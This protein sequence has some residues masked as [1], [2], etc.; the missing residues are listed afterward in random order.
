MIFL[1]LPRSINEATI[2]QL[3]TIKYIDYEIAHQI[4]EQRTL[5]E[6][7]KSFD[8]LLKVKDFPVKKSEIIKLYLNID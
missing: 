3:V 2:D 8:E 7:F 6:G 1:F 4:I 5:K